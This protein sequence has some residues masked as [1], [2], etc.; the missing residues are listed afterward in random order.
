MAGEFL[1]CSVGESPVRTTHII[2]PSPGIDELS[3]IFQIAE[4]V[5]VEALGA[6]GFVE[7]FTEGIVCWLAWTREVDLHSVAVSPQIHQLPGELWPIVTEQHLGVWRVGSEG[8]VEVRDQ[9][10]PGIYVAASLSV[11]P[12]RERGFERV[13]AASSD[14]IGQ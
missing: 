11:R 3:G 10:E 6:E 13:E 4:P 14:G 9:R 8:C 5:R 2:F 1:R 7:R 12:S